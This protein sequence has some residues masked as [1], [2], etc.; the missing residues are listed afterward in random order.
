MS[1]SNSPKLYLIRHGE[2]AW[3]IS[4]QHTGRADIPLTED[5][6]AEAERLKPA[7]AN[8]GFSQV[9][10]SPLSR[11][12]DTCVLAGLGDGAVKLDD[13]MEWN[14]GEYEGKT[15]AEIRKSIPEW[16]IWKNQ[17]TPE[18]NPPGESA[19]DAG[20]RTD[21]IIERFLVAKSDVAVFAHGHILRILAARWLGLEAEMGR[22]LVLN[23]GSISVLGFEREERALLQWNARGF[24]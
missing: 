3:S 14:Y 1:S 2:T 9:W 20:V 22:K 4:G 12:W 23:T 10:S 17:P 13:L 11:A 24:Q 15:T 7:L 21:R 8:M 5:G 18:M 16:S 6:R 19:H